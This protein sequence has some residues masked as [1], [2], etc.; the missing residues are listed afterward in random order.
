MDRLSAERPQ[1]RIFTAHMMLGIMGQFALHML[2]LLTAVQLSLPHTP[3]D[4]D[5]KSPDTA[6]QPNVLNTV[7][8]LVS[9]TATTATFIANYR[10]HPFM[11]SLRDNTWL[12]RALVAN[13]LFV[14]LMA[15]GAVQ[16]VNDVMKL[17]EMPS[18][19]LRLQLMTLVLFD[20]C[21]TV[22]Y[23]NMLKRVFAIRP[24]KSTAAKDSTAVN[25][26]TTS[27]L[28]AE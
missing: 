19:T 3:T 22:L 1:S 16:E 9:T 15:S 24:K 2:T 4:A 5:T 8:Y 25:G 18:L 6:F 27:R 14:L 10:G 11:Q 28:K 23:S 12:Y 7:V 20:L 21:S 13:V 17:A 26:Q